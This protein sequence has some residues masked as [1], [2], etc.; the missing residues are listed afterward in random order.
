MAVSSFLKLA[1]VSSISDSLSVLSTF[2]AKRQ[3]FHVSKNLALPPSFAGLPCVTPR[4]ARTHLDAALCDPAGG[5]GVVAAPPSCGKSTTLRLAF[6]DFIRG[7][8]SGVYFGAELRSPSDFFNYFG[9]DQRRADL[10]KLLPPRSAIVLDQFED[11]DSEE[12]LHLVVY[13]MHE[14]MLVGNISVTIATS[15]VRVA[16]RLLNLNGGRKVRLACAPRDFMWTP[17]EVDEFI[18]GVDALKNNIFLPR[19]REMALVSG[20]AGFLV[21]A[22]RVVN[23]QRC[24]ARWLDELSVRATSDA[25][26]WGDFVVF[27]S[28]VAQQFPVEPTCTPA[29]Q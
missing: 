15:N 25:H 29:L 21:E 10:L 22:A 2:I 12:M 18:E 27:A 1:A 23:A 7:G 8:G 17:T 19:L 24:P 11:V 4:A 5:I 6:N 28:A 16:Q 13:L 14:S 26:A 9:G 3:L 20:S